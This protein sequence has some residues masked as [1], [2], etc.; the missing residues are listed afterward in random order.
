MAHFSSHMT[1]GSS[2]TQHI[3]TSA[4]NV[5]PILC[6]SLHRSKTSGHGKQC[7]LTQGSWVPPNTLPAAGHPLAEDPEQPPQCCWTTEASN[8][9]ITPV[10]P[11]KIIAKAYFTENVFWGNDSNTWRCPCTTAA[12]GSISQPQYRV[13]APGAASSQPLSRRKDAGSEADFSLC[14]GII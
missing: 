12:Q 4:C 10:S 2:A 6:F 13:T 11:D 8:M 1:R 14:K 7:N 5:A 9:Q 3:Y